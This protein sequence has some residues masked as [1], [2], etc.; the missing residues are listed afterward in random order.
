MVRPRRLKEYEDRITAL[1]RRI[2]SF[3]TEAYYGCSNS[4]YNHRHLEALR[5]DVLRIENRLNGL[6]A[7]T[8]QRITQHEQ[9]IR[10]ITRAIQ[11]IQYQRGTVLVDSFGEHW[12]PQEDVM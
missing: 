3:E 2:V 1:E 11:V 4:L 7:L 5:A 10:S 8:Y 12:A 9:A 6:L